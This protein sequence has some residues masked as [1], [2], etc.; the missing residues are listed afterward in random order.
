MLARECILNA[1][2]AGYQSDTASSSFSGSSGQSSPKKG[3]LRDYVEKFSPEAVKEMA[4]LVSVEAA[5]L[6]SLQMKALF[7][8]YQQLQEQM[9]VNPQPSTLQE[10]GLRPSI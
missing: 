5:Q 10:N 4:S 2:P 3:S 7:G 8:D 1:A 9:Q 6:I